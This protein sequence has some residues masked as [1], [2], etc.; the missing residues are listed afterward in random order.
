MFHTFQV[1]EHRRGNTSKRRKRLVKKKARPPPAP[2][3][4]VKKTVKKITKKTKAKRKL[5]FKEK[6]G[7]DPAKKAFDDCMRDSDG[8]IGKCMKKLRESKKEASL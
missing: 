4:L 2:R 8:S 3:K 1:S 5:V 7:A 6:S